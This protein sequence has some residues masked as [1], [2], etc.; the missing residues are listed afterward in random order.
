LGHIPVFPLVLCGVVVAGDPMIR[1]LLP[2]RGRG[3]EHSPQS[4]DSDQTEG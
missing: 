1:A 4:D 3:S 2:I